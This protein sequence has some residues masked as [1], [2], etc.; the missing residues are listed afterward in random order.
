MT[1]RNDGFRSA[2]EILADLIPAERLRDAKTLRDLRLAW[3]DCVGLSAARHTRPAAWKDGVLHVE[4]DSSVWI[5]EFG[6][7]KEELLGTIRRATGRQDLHDI[8][9]HVGGRR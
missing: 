8:S 4:A 1:T 2:A 5:S 7:R 3:P 9:L 6:L